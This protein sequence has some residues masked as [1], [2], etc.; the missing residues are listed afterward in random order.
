MM[1][2]FDNLNYLTYSQA[3]RM[4]LISLILCALFV[5]LIIPAIISTVYH[6]YILRRKLKNFPQ[7]GGFPFGVIFDYI[8]RTNYG[9]EFCE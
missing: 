2:L 3:T 9:E 8:T 1:H 5:G 4:D 7:S 6:Q